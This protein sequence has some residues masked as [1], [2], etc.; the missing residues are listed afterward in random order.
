MIGPESVKAE[1]RSLL[2]RLEVA[3]ARG[4]TGLLVSPTSLHLVFTG[5]LM[6][7]KR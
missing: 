5:P 4:D 7:A 3:E 6:W 1:S 2:A